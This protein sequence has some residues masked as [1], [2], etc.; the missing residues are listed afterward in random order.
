MSS[1]AQPQPNTSRLDWLRVWHVDKS[2]PCFCNRFEI[3]H[4]KKLSAGTKTRKM[5]FVL[6][7]VFTEHATNVFML[8]YWAY[9]L[10]QSENGTLMAILPLSFMRH[11]YRYDADTVN[12][13]SVIQF[14][15]AVTLFQLLYVTLCSNPF[16]TEW[17]TNWLSDCEWQ[18]LTAGFLLTGSKYLRN[19]LT[20]KTNI[21]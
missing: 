7:L 12:R 18:W 14:I 19:W 10:Y 20:D 4:P 1:I 5:R 8:P 17:M 11:K 6:Y 15:S 2:T 9:W 13:T 16:L 3:F 21:K